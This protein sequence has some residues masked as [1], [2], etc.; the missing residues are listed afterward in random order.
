MIP[1]SL[2]PEA[3]LLLRDLTCLP[4]PGHDARCTGHVAPELDNNRCTGCR[5]AWLTAMLLFEYGSPLS[6]CGPARLEDHHA[7]TKR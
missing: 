4:P 5:V 1:I 2:V 7:G 3:I 6:D